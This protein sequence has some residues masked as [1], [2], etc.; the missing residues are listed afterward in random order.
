M[1]DNYARLV[2]QNLDRL[3]DNLPQELEHWLPARCEGNSYA[4]TAF[5][6]ACVIRPEG[7]L[8]DGHPAES[9]HAILISLY[10]LH[11]NPSACQDQPFRAFK[12]FPN[13]AP[14]IGAFASHTEQPLVNKVPQLEAAQPQL[15]AAL[16][17]EA[18]PAALGGDF[19]FV[20]TPLPKIRLCYIFHRA[21]E[22]FPA[23]VTCL[24]SSNA[25]RFL[26]LDGLADVGEYTTRRLTALSEP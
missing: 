19:A 7:I 15:M 25:D 14:Y 6:Q 9:I 24:F 22:D 13:S 2:R 4:F 5:G 3:Y 1:Q 23:A 11:A 26:P 18:A 16:D 8:L 20:L 12:E 21:D 17:G 10:A